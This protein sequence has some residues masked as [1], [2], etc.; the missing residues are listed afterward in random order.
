[1]TLRD[2]VRAADESDLA[3]EILVVGDGVDREQLRFNLPEIRSERV[4]LVVIGTSTRRGA[5]ATRNLGLARAT[6]DMVLFLD[7]DIRLMNEWPLSLRAILDAGWTCA[8]GPVTSGDTSLLSRVREDRYRRRYRSLDAGDQVGFFAG[9]NSVIRRDLLNAIG[10]FPDITV[11]S[12][13]AMLARLPPG[14]AHC[15]FAPGLRVAHVHDRGW[16]V[17]FSAA[18]R[19]GRASSL[20]SLRMEAASMRYWD[21]NTYAVGLVNLVFLAAKYGG[22]LTS[23]GSWSRWRS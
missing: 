14:A 17:A 8:T 19:S 7:D 3:L 10:G 2:L 9:G 6:A 4:R 20:A 18:W 23:R 5:A 22:F 21:D 16:R 15:R 11:G 13:S 12:D 1:M